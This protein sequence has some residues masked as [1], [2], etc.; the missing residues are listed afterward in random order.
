MERDDRLRESSLGV[1]KKGS[2]EARAIEKELEE[3]RKRRAERANSDRAAFTYSRYDGRSRGEDRRIVHAG[4]QK[5]IR[6][7]RS[8]GPR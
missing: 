5:L 6:Q 8:E 4:T 2:A 7:E 1:P 3:I